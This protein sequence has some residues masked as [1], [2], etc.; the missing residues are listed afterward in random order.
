MVALP[1]FGAVV[2]RDHCLRPRGLTVACLIP[3]SRWESRRCF[4]LGPM[5]YELG[6]TIGARSRLS[7][8]FEV[9]SRRRLPWA[10]KTPPGE[11]RSRFETAPIIS[12]TGS[13]LPGQLY[14]RLR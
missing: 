8:P 14:A 9:D 6:S 13:R 1:L 7:K 11:V 4:P 12:R 3:E 5:G 10:R 2:A